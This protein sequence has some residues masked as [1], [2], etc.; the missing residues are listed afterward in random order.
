M[1]AVTGI[2]L[3]GYGLAF[4]GVCWYNHTK[5][6]AMRAKQASQAQQ[7]KDAEG[8]DETSKMPML[9]SLHGKTPKTGTATNRF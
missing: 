3:A 6:Q 1:Q 9:G 5:L 2:N 7:A 4:L 8:A